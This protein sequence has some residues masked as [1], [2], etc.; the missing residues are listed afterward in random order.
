MTAT[1]HIARRTTA[2]H[3]LAALRERW[4]AFL[5]RHS[6]RAQAAYFERLHDSL[7]L[8][9][10]DRHALEPAALEAAFAQLAA[11][12]PETVTPADGGPTARDRDRE[13]QLLAVCDAWFREA[14]PG[15]EHRWH[16]MTVASYQRLMDDVRACFHPGG[17]Q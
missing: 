10:P 4:D 17:E 11:D 9:D 13:Q 8:D 5:L 6:A 3:P 2:H 7:P 1:V 14:H 12:H 15:P 16:P